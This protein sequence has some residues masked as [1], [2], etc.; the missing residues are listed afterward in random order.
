MKTHPPHAH[1]RPPSP[2]L[3]VLGALALLPAACGGGGAG[4]N[5]GNWLGEHLY[6][7]CDGESVSDV[8]PLD[9]SCSGT[10][11]GLP[12]T[13]SF[14][15]LL[16]G[17]LPIARDGAFSGV[18]GTIT[19]DG[20]FTSATEA[21]G[22]LVF[23]APDGCC[24]AEVAWTATWRPPQYADAAAP[25]AGAGADLV[26][27]DDDLTPAQAAAIRITNEWRARIGAAPLA[28]SAPIHRAAQAHADYFAANCDRLRAEGL[29]PHVESAEHPGYTG[30]SFFDRLQAQGWSGAGGWEIMAFQADPAEA[31]E[32][33]LETLY[34]R[35]P[36]V[37][38]NAIEAGYGGAAGS[39]DGC[40]GAQVDVM[41]FGRGRTDAT[42][43]VRFPPDGATDVRPSWHGLESPQPPLPPGESYPS[44]PIVTLTFPEGP[45]L[46][47]T[48]HRLAGPDGVDI[49]HVLRTPS[50]DRYLDGTIALYAH[51]PLA[52]GTTYDVTLEGRRGTAAFAE[53]WT[54]TTTR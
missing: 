54:F 19:L 48:G 1:R 50:D 42:A 9:V 8:R 43:P 53:T 46:S 7:A 10:L 15:G 16:A 41:D 36:L 17:S 49:P 26:R 27:P 6:F 21:G 4:P 11:D 52:P 23:D 47:V 31:I 20:R 30:A 13:A 25:D 44:G 28:S 24:R 12:C 3:L 45:A 32:A 34:H 40:R 14:A 39:G 2:L 37:H 22:T 29:S 38:P 51:D 5:E 35:I 18:L 33:W